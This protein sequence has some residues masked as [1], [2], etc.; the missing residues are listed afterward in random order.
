MAGYGTP[1]FV[2][3]PVIPGQSKETVLALLGTERTVC[4]RAKCSR[5]TELR[6]CRIAFVEDGVEVQGEGVTRDGL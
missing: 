3:S 2:A 6:D 5:G 1:Y 4:V